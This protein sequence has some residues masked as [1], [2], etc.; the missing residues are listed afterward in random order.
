MPPEISD[1]KRREGPSPHYV[2]AHQLLKELVKDERFWSALSRSTDNDDGAAEHVFRKMW[3]DCG[4]DDAL[5]PKPERISGGVLVRMPPPDE[6]TEC[7]YVVIFPTD[8]KRRYYTLEKS[9]SVDVLCEWTDEAHVSFGPCSRN[10][11]EFI[12]A[13][14]KKLLQATAN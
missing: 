4:G 7:W 3:A 13:A 8:T 2:F 1:E 6:I 9:I 11:D 10:E 14:R 5:R 12:A